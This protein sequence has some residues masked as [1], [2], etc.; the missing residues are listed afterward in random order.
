MDVLESMALENV[1]LP[2]FGKIRGENSPKTMLYDTF[3]RVH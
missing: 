2:R 3:R 1:T